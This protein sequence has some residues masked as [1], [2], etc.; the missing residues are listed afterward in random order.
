MSL[1]HQHPNDTVL[2]TRTTK[3]ISSLRSMHT[4]Q[5]TRDLLSCAALTAI[6]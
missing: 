2:N 4:Q 6:I 3:R 5:R 1:D